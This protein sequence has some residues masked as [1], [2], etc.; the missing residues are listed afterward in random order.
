MT[1]H[2]KAANEAQL[3][4]KYLASQN[5]LSNIELRPRTMSYFTH[6]HD[7]RSAA[8]INVKSKH[9][10]KFDSQTSIIGNNQMR[11]RQIAKAC[12]CLPP[13]LLAAL[14]TTTL[15]CSSSSTSPT[16]AAGAIDSH[17]SRA[18]CDVVGCERRIP[19]DEIRVESVDRAF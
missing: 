13:P 11:S 16:T 19:S 14:P 10:A 3:K 1:S 18:G 6:I 4:I 17:Q 7:L 2:I 9:D 5:C 8:T 12:P 15:I